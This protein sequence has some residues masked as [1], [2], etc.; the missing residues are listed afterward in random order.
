MYSPVC[1]IGS[2]NCNSITKIFSFHATE[3]L[4]GLFNFNVKTSTAQNTVQ[5]KQRRCTQ[6]LH[7]VLMC[8]SSQENTILLQYFTGYVQF[9]AI[10]KQSI[11]Q[12]PSLFLILINER[13]SR[14]G[15]QEGIPREHAD[16]AVHF[17]FHHANLLQEL[18]AFCHAF[19]WVI[20]TI[21]TISELNGESE[22]DQSSFVV[23]L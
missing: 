8:R 7:I 16:V 23:E 5:Q 10:R 11:M 12:H 1:I 6:L 13:E 18:K 15:I 2:M 20:T 9:R 4:W 17:S 19:D 14:R 3:S 22:N 21:H